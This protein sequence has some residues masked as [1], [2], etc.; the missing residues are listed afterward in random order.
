MK[1]L[2]VILLT[3]GNPNNNLDTFIEG[4]FYS[5]LKACQEAGKQFKIDSQLP[6]YSAK[7]AC[8][9]TETRKVFGLDEKEAML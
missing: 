6:L 9:N 8:A 2:L 1:Y 4:P 7:I 3:Y 5:E